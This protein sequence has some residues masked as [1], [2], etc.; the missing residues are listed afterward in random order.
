[1]TPFQFYYLYKDSV[2]KDSQIYMFLDQDAKILFP[3]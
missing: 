1:M 2:S 3:L